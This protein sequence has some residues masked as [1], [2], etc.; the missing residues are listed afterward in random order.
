MR[1]I[2]FKPNFA[3]IIKPSLK[4]RRSSQTRISS[5]IKD[6]IWIDDSPI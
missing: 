2:E 5:K 3:P 6:R 4:I 1:P